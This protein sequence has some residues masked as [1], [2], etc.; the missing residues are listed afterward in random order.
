MQ[1]DNFQDYADGDSDFIDCKGQNES[2]MEQN[3]KFF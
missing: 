2:L 1:K 3:E